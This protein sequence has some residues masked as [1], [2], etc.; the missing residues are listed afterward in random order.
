[1]L[2]VVVGGFAALVHGASR[3]TYDIDVTPSTS[4]DNL[5]RLAAALT[6]MGARIRTEDVADGLPF[7]VSADSLRG[8]R[9]LN[10]TTPLGELD[11]TFEPD[12]VGG[13]DCWTHNAETPVSH[14]I[15]LVAVTCVLVQTLGD[16]VGRYGAAP[17]LLAEMLGSAAPLLGNGPAQVRTSSLSPGRTSGRFPGG[18]V[19]PRHR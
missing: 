3:P 8:M 15:V 5:G 16:E 10:L 9:T 6:E 2:Y 1:M 17:L 4:A 14:L 18:R 12:G 11:L 7:A 13:F 19:L